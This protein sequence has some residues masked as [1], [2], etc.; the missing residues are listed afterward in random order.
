MNLVR[1][2]ASLL[3]LGSAHRKASSCARRTIA[4]SMC[5]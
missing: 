4:L 3:G 2:I 1:Y 5:P